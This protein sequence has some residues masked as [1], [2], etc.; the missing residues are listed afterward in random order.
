[1]LGFFMVSPQIVKRN[2]WPLRLR[3]LIANWF[4]DASCHKNVRPG[5]RLTHESRHNVMR[6]SFGVR[7]KAAG[8]GSAGDDPAPCH[9]EAASAPLMGQ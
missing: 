2:D 8:Q 3:M 5:V 6:F 1:M 9:M 4:G 7:R